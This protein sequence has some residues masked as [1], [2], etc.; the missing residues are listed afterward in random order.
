MT[1]LIWEGKYRDGKKVEPARIALPFQT[2]ES[3]NLFPDHPP[4]WHNRLI[5]GDKKY[6]L[7]S[8][9]PEFAG[10][11][12]LV[13]IDPPFDTGADFSLMI[14][15]PHNNEGFTGEAGRMEQ[16][17]YRDTWGRG[18]DSYLQWFYETVVLLR[19]LLAAHGSIFVHLDWRAGHYGK[20]ILDEV[21][22]QD[23]LRNE[24]IWCYTGP[25]SPGMQQFN[26]KHDTIFWYS[27]SSQW[28]FNEKAIRVPH[29]AKTK[30]NF[31][32]GL[33]GS[34]F[35]ADTYVLDEQG[36]IPEDWWQI[37]IAGRYAID[38]VNRAG[39]PTEK[40]ALLLERIIK[41]ASNPGD[42]VLDCFCGSGTTAAVAEKLGRSWI[43][44]DLGRFAIH[45]TRK[46][47]LSIENVKSFVVQNLDKY[48]RQAWQAAEF[49]DPMQSHYRNFILDLYRATPVDGYT[50]IHGIKDGRLVHVGSVDAPIAL[51]DVKSIVNEFWHVREQYASEHSN[52]VDMLGWDFAF[53]LNEAA[54][55]MAAD[56]NIHLA[57][58]RIPRE[59]LE[60]R[61]VEQGEIIF[62]ELA[63]LDI[64]VRQLKQ[65]IEVELKDFFMPLDD[66]PQNVSRAISHWSQC[67]DYW[68][69]D[70]DY[71]D[72]IFH[73]RWQ[74]YRSRKQ[75]DILLQASHE[76]DAPGS[77][78]IISKVID[79]LGNETTKVVRVE[80]SF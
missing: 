6:V 13:Y 32:A 22:G 56:A 35:V 71:R 37:A 58:K 57:F 24:I 1:E 64:E 76:Y 23:N 27:K 51:D 63:A 3:V 38:G 50:W 10:K 55:Q 31:K 33:V 20:A 42:V 14:T 69:L 36:K 48:E 44:C 26:R 28:V 60:K 66:V 75:P 15:L 30:A 78:M 72:D 5:W 77:Y 40:P 74:A 19:E 34:G 49:A 7:P 68:A 41:A 21:F 47:L 18:L 4:A 65:R 17:A 25:G 8:L 16:K 79:I 2:I 80:V 61:A 43:T 9:L 53:D 59:M 39:Y 45:T 11:V 52:G 70:W 62:Y 29:H 12:D 54:K 46:R 73:N 67:I